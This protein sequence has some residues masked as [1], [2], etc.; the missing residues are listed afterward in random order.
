MFP[1]QFD[2]IVNDGSCFRAVTRHRLGFP[3]ALWPIS[4]KKEP[5]TCVLRVLAV[6]E[7]PPTAS[8]RG[9]RSAGLAFASARPLCPKLPFMHLTAIF[10]SLSG[11]ISILPRPARSR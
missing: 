1:T 9:R 3:L 10:N 2:A 8:T 7:Q 6:K 5:A 4:N 11:L